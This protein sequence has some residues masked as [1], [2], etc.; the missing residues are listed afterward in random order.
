MKYFQFFDLPVSFY[1]DEKELKKRFLINSKKYHPDFFTLEG[2]EK[3]SEILELSTL[4][5]NAYKTLSDFDA[6]MEY[7]LREK[8]ILADEGNNTIPQAFLMQV[9]EIQE[10]I[11][12]LE[13]GYDGQ[14]LQS[15]LQQVQQL[16]KELEDGIRPVLTSYHN[17]TTTKEE[18][19]KVKDFYLKKKYL[20]RIKENLNKFAPVS[21][22]T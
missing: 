1:L 13:F 2:E 6:R 20:W 11:M 17:E 19:E 4:N 16:E 5:N 3:Q 9:M 14:A 8:G 12:E 18:L 10:A 15:A 22:E 21:K 7:I